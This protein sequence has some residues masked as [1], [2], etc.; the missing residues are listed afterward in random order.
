MLKVAVI[1][2]IDP[3]YRRAGVAKVLIQKALS[4]RSTGDIP[5]WQYPMLG[6]INVLASI[7]TDQSRQRDVAIL[8]EV[9]SA[10]QQIFDVIVKDFHLLTPLNKLGDNRR[11]VV[12]AALSLF[13]EDPETKRKLYEREM[14]RLI[15]HCWVDMSPHSPLRKYPTALLVCLT[16]TE[17][18]YGPLPPPDYLERIFQVVDIPRF[19]SRFNFLF[20]QKHIPGD[21]LWQDLSLAMHLT[22]GSWLP[23]GPH[24]TQAGVPKQVLLAILRSLKGPSEHLCI[25]FSL[26]EVF[27]QELI[28]NS[29]YPM[30]TLVDMINN[31]RLIEVAAEGFKKANRAP[32]HTQRIDDAGTFYQFFQNIGHALG[33]ADTTSCKLH[34]TPAFR[35]GMRANVERIGITTFISLQEE[36]GADGKYL[37]LWT[38]LT[39][40]LGITDE[41]IR[42]RYQMDR[43]CCNLECPFRNAGCQKN[44]WRNHKQECKALLE[45]A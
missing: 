42:E 11:G 2:A 4:G 28:L 17:E 21:V 40:L 3:R 13:R 19:V 25:L 9:Y 43:K 34:C 20:K 37:E 26:G 38:G 23:F 39:R 10:F 6:I 27:T 16:S 35:D 1:T 7:R 29:P 15:V 41:S 18:L 14:L 32:S 24:F 31:T 22:R 30:G 8:R 12:A 33:C 44:D 45:D 5:Y 36:L